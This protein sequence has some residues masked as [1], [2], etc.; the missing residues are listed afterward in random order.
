MFDR[1][2]SSFKNICDIYY[3]QVQYNLEY[4][5]RKKYIKPSNNYNDIKNIISAFDSKYEYDK[6]CC[7][8]LNPHLNDIFVK[9]KCG[10]DMHYLCLEN[11][12]LRNQV[13]PFC[14]ENVQ[15]EN[16]INDINNLNFKYNIEEMYYK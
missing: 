6:Y 13:C 12:I 15:D 10:H 3:N 11:F 8:C 4:L 9:L 7:Y 16:E 1:F 5:L 2:I 14:K